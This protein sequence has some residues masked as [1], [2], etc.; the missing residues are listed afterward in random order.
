MSENLF[1]GLYEG[2]TLIST[3]GEYELKLD[4][5]SFEPHLLL[6]PKNYGAGAYHIFK[7]DKFQ[8]SLL[9]MKEWVV[10]EEKE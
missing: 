6:H 3:D 9:A 1:R 8:W 10:K 5:D 2:K 4:I 7:G